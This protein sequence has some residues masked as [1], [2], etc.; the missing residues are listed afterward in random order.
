MSEHQNAFFESCHPQLRCLK[1]IP[2]ARF[3]PT[4]DITRYKLGEGEL[5]YIPQ[6]ADDPDML[7][8]EAKKLSFTPR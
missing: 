8:R 7:Y 6:C 1:I 5:L 3:V 2:L 4:K